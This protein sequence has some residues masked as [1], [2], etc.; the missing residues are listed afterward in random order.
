MQSLSSR[1]LSSTRASFSSSEGVDD[2][3]SVSEGI[4]PLNPAVT[5]DYLPAYLF[6]SDKANLLDIAESGKMG[7]FVRYFLEESAAQV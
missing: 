1:A 6:V 2:D 3:F 5:L 7:R 4:F